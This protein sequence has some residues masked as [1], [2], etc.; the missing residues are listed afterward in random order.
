MLLVGDLLGRV[1]VITDPK[2]TTEEVAGRL[3]EGLF[4]LL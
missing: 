3:S 4:A 2:S 1:R